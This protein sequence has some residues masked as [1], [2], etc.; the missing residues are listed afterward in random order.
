MNMVLYIHPERRNASLWQ[1]ENSAA[2]RENY[3]WSINDSSWI[4]TLNMNRNI[5]AYFQL[6]LF[7]QSSC[8]N[9]ISKFWVIKV[10][11]PKTLT[12][13]TPPGG[14]LSHS[15]KLTFDVCFPGSKPLTPQ[16]FPS[17]RSEPQMH[18][19]SLRHVGTHMRPFLQK[20]ISFLIWS[21][22]CSSCTI[23]CC[24]YFHSPLY[25]QVVD[26]IMGVLGMLL[27]SQWIQ[28]RLMGLQCKWHSH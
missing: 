24:L 8:Q 7:K 17:F 1:R 21:C 13:P 19:Q 28:H 20:N 26:G 11:V 16:Y 12:I 25:W 27:L 9:Q 14:T 22:L 23:S 4:S 5:L 2:E 10:Y 6:H 18:S 15:D 3:F